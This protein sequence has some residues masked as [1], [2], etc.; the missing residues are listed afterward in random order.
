M[1]YHLAQDETWMRCRA[2]K[3]NGQSVSL[4]PVGDRDHVVGRQGI[5]AQ[6]GGIESRS[7]NGERIRIRISPMS[8]EGTF[9]ATSPKGL[10]RRYFAD[11]THVKFRDRLLFEMTNSA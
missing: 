2:K 6:G 7:E 1:K 5:A 4:C 11:G 3:R 10:Q 9:T 8:S